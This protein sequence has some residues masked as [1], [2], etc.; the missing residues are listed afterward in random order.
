MDLETIAKYQ[1]I[2]EQYA[3]KDNEIENGK[4][5][6]GKVWQDYPEIIEQQYATV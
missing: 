1:K 2:F 5:L 6:N 3:N 4:E